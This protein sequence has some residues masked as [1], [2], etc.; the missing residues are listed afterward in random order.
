MLYPAAFL[1]ALADRLSRLEPRGAAALVAIDGWGCS[2][3][4]ALAEGLLDRLEP[5]FQY[6][7]ADE[8]FAGFDVVEPG[9][10]P[11]LRWREL[12]SAVEG[13]SRAG[14]AQVRG[15]DW[16]GGRIMEAAPIEGRAWLVEGLFCLRPELRPRY[17]LAIW[18]QGRLE[19]RLVRVARRDGAHMI[20]YWEREWMPRERAYVESE[21]PWTAADI[22]VAGADI[23]IAEVGERLV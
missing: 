9:P 3:K 18:V 15:Y 22:V 10:V 12:C 13:L 1:D 20:P 7:S 4:T 16:E 11:H 2:G 8:F 19:D 14:R 6:L 17:D 21:R 5:T 23:E